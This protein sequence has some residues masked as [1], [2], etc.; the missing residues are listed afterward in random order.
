MKKSL[1]LLLCL[2]LIFKS[3]AD[4]KPAVSIGAS[5]G[6]CFTSHGVSFG[7]DFNVGLWESKILEKTVRTG[8]CFS[9]LWTAANVANMHHTH[10]QNTINLLVQTKKIDFKTGFGY[11]RNPWGYRNQNSCEV[12]GINLD[13]NYKL[14]VNENISLGY[15][16]FYFK[17][18]DWRWLDQPYQTIY[19]KYN[20]NFTKNLN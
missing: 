5:F 6:Y 1:L 14:P 19:A 9:K 10:K 11:V 2:F 20:H 18:R 12:H 15:R 8:L 4:L 13:L 7:L 16:S 17:R 3:F